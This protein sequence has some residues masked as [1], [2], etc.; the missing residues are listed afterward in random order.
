MIRKSNGVSN[1]DENAA[2]AE[3]VR[4]L[5]LRESHGVNVLSIIFSGSLIL[6]DKAIL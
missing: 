5:F 2:I 4:D 3:L 1:C 6:Q